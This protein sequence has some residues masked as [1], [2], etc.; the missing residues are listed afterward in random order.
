MTQQSHPAVVPAS[1]ESSVE[2]GLRLAATPASSARAAASLASVIAEH[3]GVGIRLAGVE[4]VGSRVHF[5]L[6]IALG[7]LDDVTSA[8]IASRAAVAAL[9]DIIGSL[10]VL[11]PALV[12]MPRP[13]STEARA[14]RA[15]IARHRGIDEAALVALSEELL[16]VG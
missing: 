2:I 9:Q 6:A 12:P 13:D 1:I 8:G 5:T 3:P 14:A 4:S 11:D 16:S 7:N 10:A 15:L